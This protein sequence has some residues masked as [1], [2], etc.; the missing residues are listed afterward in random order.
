[1]TVIVEKPKDSLENEVSVCSIQLAGFKKQENSGMRCSS[2]LYKNV[3]EP[4]AWLQ[5]GAV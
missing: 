3:Q 2:C 5:L 4:L 1:V